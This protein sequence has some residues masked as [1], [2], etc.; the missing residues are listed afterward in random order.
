V[1]V[2]WVYFNSEEHADWSTLKNSV[3]LE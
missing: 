3:S 2:K 1:T